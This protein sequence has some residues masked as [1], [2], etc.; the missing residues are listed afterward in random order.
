VRHGYVRGASY[1][2]LAKN[3]AHKDNSNIEI[4]P[5]AQVDIPTIV[6]NFAN[7]D[8][9]K[10]ISTFQTY[11]QEQAEGVRQVWIAHLG[12]QF[13]GY[14]TLSWKSNYKSFYDQGI[15]EIM[16][17][18]VLPSFRKHGVGSRLLDTAEAM[19][20]TKTNR[21]GLGVG[22]YPGYS[23]AQRVYVQHGYIPDGRGITYNYQSI[24]PS[25]NVPLDDDL[26]LWFI[27]QLS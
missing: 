27:K 5:F 9:P 11:W 22:L 24:T 25:N 21:V 10:P 16:D 2:Y 4:R 3:L 7:A 8:W 23:S 17:L 13:A 6:T 26:V 12:Q 15:P 18:N 20:V 14:V 19:A 1:Y